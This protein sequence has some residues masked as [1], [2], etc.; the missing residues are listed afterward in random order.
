MK[1]SCLLILCVLCMTLPALAASIQ[2]TTPAANTSWKINTTK[3]IQWDFTGIDAAATVRIILWKGGDKIGIIANQLAIG[4]NGQGSY[5]WKVGSV[6]DAEAAAPGSGYFIKVRTTDD[7]ASGQSGTFSMIRDATTP[8]SPTSQ[9]GSQYQF[10]PKPGQVL[11]GTSSAQLKRIQVTSPKAGDV[12]APTGTYGIYWNFVNIPAVDVSLTLLRDGEPAGTP[13]GSS[14]DANG[15]HWNLNLQPP[16]PGTY[17][18]AVE[19]LDHAYRGLSGAFMVDEQG[20]IEPL[21]PNQGMTFVNGSSQEV[22]WKRAGNIQKLD[23][24]LHRD[25]TSWSQS[26]AVGVDAKLEKL[27]VVLNPG[28]SGQYRITFK[29]TMDG[30]YSYAHSGNFTIQV[31]P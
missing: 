3:A 7:T 20:W 17:K 14:S 11:P 6:M 25:G 30:G 16:D 13:N 19:T 23:L 24:T 1:T 9:P 26:L 5:S 2:V 10:A 12:L 28:E 21:F 31:A 22:R 15:L 29:Y 8:G 18:V 27:A 4:A